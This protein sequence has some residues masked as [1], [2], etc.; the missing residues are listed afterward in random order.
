M[1]KPNQLVFIGNLEFDRQ[2]SMSRYLTMLEQIEFSN[3]LKPITIKPKSYFSKITNKPHQGIGK[4]FSYL[5]KLIIFPI[6]LLLKRLIYK[7]KGNNSIYH[8]IDHSN[9][10]YLIFL[11][12]KK[13][14]ITCHDMLAIKGALGY[15]DA[16]CETSKTGQLLQY[17]ISTML[18]KANHI[19]F[20]SKKT[21]NDFYEICRPEKQINEEVIYHTNN[22]N[23]TNLDKNNANEYLK[24]KFGINYNFIIHIGSNLKRKNK[25]LLFEFL[26]INKNIHL[27]FIGPNFG[28]EQTQLIENL[29]IVD[30]ISVYNGVNTEDLNNFLSAADCLIFPSYSEGFGWPIIEAFKSGCPVIAS[31]I[32]PF[33]EI[34]EDAC[35][36]FNPNEISELNS[37]YQKLLDER[38][39]ENLL[40][41]SQLILKKFE[42]SKMNFSYTE[43]YYKLI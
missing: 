40:K 7:L 15:K 12:K 33:L 16:Y 26:S 13:T 14:I 37:A 22:Q 29:K 36:Y 27:I 17:L 11:P 10:F 41:N 18:K 1:T 2:V 25:E 23:L 24:K 21:K 20:V 8:I 32:E 42:N 3:N 19:I 31:N 4:L 5:D 38:Y 28:I 34:G 6:I 30:K 35:I 39:C 9:S 43:F